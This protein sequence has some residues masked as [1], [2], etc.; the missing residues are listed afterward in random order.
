MITPSGYPVSF[1][2]RHSKKG[3]NAPGLHFRDSQVDHI[4][5]KSLAK[6]KSEVQRVKLGLVENTFFAKR[7]C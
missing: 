7:E 4:F 3:S 6:G 1:S 5:T 2:E